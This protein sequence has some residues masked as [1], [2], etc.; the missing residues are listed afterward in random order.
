MCKYSTV[1][2]RCGLT[3]E[4]RAEY[5]N[6]QDVTL[7]LSSDCPNL[8]IVSQSPLTLDAMRELMVPKEKSEFMKLLGENSHPGDCSVYESV[9]DA[10]G[11]SLG[12]Y[13]EIA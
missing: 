2:K 13:Y 3:I 1:C 5:K 9:I 8:D 10:I 4:V 6:M 12:R 7:N 11:Q